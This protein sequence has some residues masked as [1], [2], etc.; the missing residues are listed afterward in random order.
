MRTIAIVAVMAAMASAGCHQS[1]VGQEIP[2]S[3][4]VRSGWDLYQ[5]GSVISTQAGGR[6]VFHG[7]FRLA[8]VD[9]CPAH[10]D[11]DVPPELRLI[12]AAYSRD[13]DRDRDG[14][15]EATSIV[16]LAAAEGSECQTV[17]VETDPPGGDMLAVVAN[18]ATPG[19]IVLAVRMW[20]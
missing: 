5:P 15:Y 19:D 3:A 17:T 7:R 8:E 2:A 6:L 16:G 10:L 14:P 18:A 1:A 4:G 9:V 13:V 11:D 12:V 20:Q